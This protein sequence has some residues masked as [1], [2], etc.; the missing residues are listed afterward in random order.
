MENKKEKRLFKII[1]LVLIGFFIGV[2]GMYAIIHFFPTKFKEIINTN[3]T[4]I[5]KDVSITDTGLAEAV[6]KI[7]DAVVVVENYKSDIK[8]ASGT[9]FV[10]KKD[11]NKGYILTNNHVISG[12]TD[13]YVTFTNGKRKEA[14][15]LGA[16]TYA[17]IAVLCIEAFDDMKIATIGNSESAKVGDTVFAVGAPLDSSTYSWTVTRGILSGK[18]RMI[19]LSS[20][21]TSNVAINDWVMAALQTDAAINSGNSGGPLSNANGEVIGITSLKLVKSGVEGMG[22]AI[23]IE[24]AI[25]YSKKLEKKEQ[26]T[27]PYMGISMYNVIDLNKNYYDYEKITSGVYVAE[28]EESSPA[29]K[30]GLKKGDIIIKIDKTEVKN[31]AY[32]KY[33]LYKYSVND[34]V[35]LTIYR[36]DAEKTINMTLGEKQN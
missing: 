5:V 31:V 27:R 21:S 32:L 2:A 1:L 12:A 19:E 25:D 26:I 11:G 29:D 22:F 18:D 13:V 35:K 23:P 6:D 9:G 20:S 17:D 33:N 34:K 24:T 4:K 28:V 16:D 3:T 30:A 8:A 14:E 7:Y 15:V 36:N 10:Y